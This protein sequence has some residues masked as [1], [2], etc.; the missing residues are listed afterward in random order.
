MM[1]RKNV[2]MQLGVGVG[3]EFKIVFSH[4]SCTFLSQYAYEQM[5]LRVFVQDVK[6]EQI[7]LLTHLTFAVHGCKTLFSPYTVPSG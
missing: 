2:G 7:I 5:L 6:L 1:R 3:R 4:W